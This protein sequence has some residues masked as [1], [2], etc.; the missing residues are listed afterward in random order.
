MELELLFQN[1]KELKDSKELKEKLA[2]VAQGA[3]PHAA[4]ILVALVTR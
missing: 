2:E 4:D 3:L 1:W